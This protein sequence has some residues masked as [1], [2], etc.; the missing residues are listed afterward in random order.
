MMVLSRKSSIVLWLVAVPLLALSVIRPPNLRNDRAARFPTKLAGYTLV[1][2]NKIQKRHF[3]LLGTRDVA[4]WNYR[5]ENGKKYVLT[6]IFHDS[7]WK[8][9]HPPHICIRGSNFSLNSDRSVTDT[10]PDGREISLGRLLATENRGRKRDYV[11]LYAF[12][13]RDFVTPNYFRFYFEHAPRALFR[14]A[15]SGFLLRVEAFVGKDGP[16]ATEKRCWKMFQTFLLA[17]EDLIRPP[18]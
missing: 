10:L 7:N 2:K 13:G 14:Q 9:L 8:S 4:W 15:T 5:D 1:S 18:E 16:R 12:V 6:I 11:S 3:Q 17:G